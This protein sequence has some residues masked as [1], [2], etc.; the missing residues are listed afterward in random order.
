[1][2][3]KSFYA[4]QVLIELQ[5]DFRNLDFKIDEREVFLRMDA[6]VNELA[7]KNYF[8]NWKLSGASIDEGFIT[9]WEPVAVV[10]QNNGLPSYFIFPSNYAALPRNAGINEV[11]PIKFISENQPPVVIMSHTD[12]RRYLSN[13]ASKMGGRLAGYP[14]GGRFYFTTCE[15]GKNYGNMGVRLVVRDSSTIGDNDLYPIPA[16]KENEVVATLVQWFRDRRLQPT[17]SVRDNKDA[18]KS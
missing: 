6:M 11:Y 13:P 9:T 17:D 18:V 14:H 2:K 10:D 4:E 7:A 1:M 12:Y 15:V 8:E 3:T 5:D 16:D